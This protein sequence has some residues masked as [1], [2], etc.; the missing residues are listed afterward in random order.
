V[1]EAF[2]RAR[3]AIAEVAR[4]TAQMIEK[5]GAARPDWVEVEFGLKL[6]A[7]GTAIMAGAAGEAS[8]KVTLGYDT[9]SRPA[10]GMPLS[11]SAS[12][13]GDRAKGAADRDADRCIR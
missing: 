1:L 9:S 7:T 11:A 2:S 10:D 5:A 4:S 13:G 6:S 8:L 12:A 3:E